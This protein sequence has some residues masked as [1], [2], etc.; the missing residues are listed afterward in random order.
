[1]RARMSRLTRALTFLRPERVVLAKRTEQ[2]RVAVLWDDSGSMATRDVV[3][4][5][6]ATT[7]RAESRFW[8]TASSSTP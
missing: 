6:K 8:A 2:P 5:D 4:G 3:T 1:M 7:S